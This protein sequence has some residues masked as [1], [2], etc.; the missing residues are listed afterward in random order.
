M[1]IERRQNRANPTGRI[2]GWKQILNALT[3]HDRI[4]VEN[5]DVTIRLHTRS[6]NPIVD[7]WGSGCEL[8]VPVH[9]R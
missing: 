2:P 4:A 9:A 3:I 1:A 5:C 7:I 8:R 6:D